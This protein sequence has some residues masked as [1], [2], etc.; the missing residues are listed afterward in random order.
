[1]PAARERAREVI[2][3]VGLGPKIDAAAAALT[4]AERKRLE[5][6]RALATE[7]RLL[8]LDEVMAGLN[9]AETAALVELIRRINRSG[10][11]ILLIEHN[12]RAVMS[13]SHRLV[14][15]SFGEQIAEGPPEAIASHPKVIEAYLGEE[16][17]HA[18]P[19]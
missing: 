4:L 16:Y 1:V 17:V 13:L 6:A 9:P 15:L 5:L 14:V 8:L 11:S 19:A 3:L 10:V 7:P 18:P 12:M 2:A